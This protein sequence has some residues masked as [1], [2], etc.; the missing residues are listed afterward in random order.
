MASAELSRRVGK[1]VGYPPLSEMGD[2]PA[3]RVP[4]G[5]ARGCGRAA[6]AAADPARLLRRTFASLLYGIGEASPVVMAELGHTD[7]GLAVSIYAHAMRREDGENDRLRV[8]VNG[9]E[10]AVIEAGGVAVSG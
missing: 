6:A 7:L 3:A 10:F 5:A 1:V 9:E 2:R 8:L 4:R